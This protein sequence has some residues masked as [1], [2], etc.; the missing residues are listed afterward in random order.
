[1]S[2]RRCS[3]CALDWPDRQAFR[4]CH[5]C[6][7]RTDWVSNADAMPEPEATSLERRLRFEREYEKYDRGEESECGP[8]R[9]GPT[10]EFVGALEA[11]AIIEL[12]RSHPEVSGRGTI[13]S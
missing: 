1:M 8:G 10:P 2:A 11:R 6:G 5:Q 12:E 3:R 13:E 4:R 9:E 7:G